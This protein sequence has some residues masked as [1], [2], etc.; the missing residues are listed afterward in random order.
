MD[1]DE[2][3]ILPMRVPKTSNGNPG[4]I[5]AQP[6]TL[7]GFGVP[8]SDMEGRMGDSHLHTPYGTHLVLAGKVLGW[9]LQGR[10]PLAH[11]CSQYR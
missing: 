8:A 7:L 1:M 9:P 5:T 3:S 2:T 11:P 6:P 4:R 10:P